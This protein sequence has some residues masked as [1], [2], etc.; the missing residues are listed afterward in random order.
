MIIYDKHVVYCNPQYQTT[1]QKLG[2]LIH[3]EFRIDTKVLFLHHPHQ[4]GAPGGRRRILRRLIDFEQLQRR[5]GLGGTMVTGKNQDFNAE[6][7]LSKD[8]NSKNM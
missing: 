5:A 3:F 2:I 4:L 7:C 1:Q 6:K 8:K